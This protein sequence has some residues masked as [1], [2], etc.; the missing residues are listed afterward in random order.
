MGPMAIYILELQT[1][2]EVEIADNPCRVLPHWMLAQ[3]DS[4]PMAVHHFPST[5]S[6]INA[7]SDG[8]A[9]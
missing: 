3:N 6:G 7:G 8:I 9:G 2:I 5:D 1:S 4:L